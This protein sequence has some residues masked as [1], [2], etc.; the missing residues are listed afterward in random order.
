MVEVLPDLKVEIREAL[1]TS[2]P[3]QPYQQFADVY[4]REHSTGI[5][6]H[7]TICL[8]PGKRFVIRLFVGTDFDWLNANAIKLRIDFDAGTKVKE[9][10][11][12][13]LR[14]HDPA[15][16]QAPWLE[17]CTG[18]SEVYIERL[19]RQLPRDCE[20]DFRF[21]T[22]LIDQT[23]STSNSAKHT[24]R[25]SVTVILERY[26]IQASDLATMPHRVS[27]NKTKGGFK[28]DDALTSTE[29]CDQSKV[30]RSSEYNLRMCRQPKGKADC[31]DKKFQLH[32][33][34]PEIYK[35]MM[36]NDEANN[37]YEEV[38]SNE[39][40]VSTPSPAPSDTH[41]SNATL[42]SSENNSLSIPADSHTNIGRDESMGDTIEVKTEQNSSIMGDEVD[43]DSGRHA[44]QADEV[45][46]AGLVAPEATANSSTGS[47]GSDTAID[48]T[49]DENTKL[50][51]QQQLQ[52]WDS[53]RQTLASANALIDEWNETHKRRLDAGAGASRKKARVE[54]QGKKAVEQEHKEKMK[55]ST[56]GKQPSKLRP[57]CP[58][59]P[60]DNT[61]AVPDQSR[62]PRSVLAVLPKTKALPDGGK[63]G[64]R[65]D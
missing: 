41:A 56:R 11:A 13:V 20:Q 10:D 27:L 42:A 4:D 58:L 28:S 25:G 36:E 61:A 17:S 43:I 31:Y 54:Q 50:V 60:I 30:R 14:E 53:N 9:V 7:R 19:I 1:P 65:V 24:Q 45:D 23:A 2:G 5:C 52:S 51:E 32:Y 62:W 49:E 37:K 6:T 3:P 33:R 34:T 16:W 29:L 38:G 57:Q 55:P 15:I 21:M 63:H 8:R 64:T 44:H 46:I 48:S 26:C 22:K 12:F 40:K 35:R 39:T 59:D 18:G 47:D